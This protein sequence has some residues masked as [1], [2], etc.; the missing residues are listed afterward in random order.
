MLQVP[1]ARAPSAG[2][3]SSA[4]ALALASLAIGVARLADAQCLAGSARI[5]KAN[6][7]GQLNEVSV[8]DDTGANVLT[9]GNAAGVVSCATSVYNG[10]YCGGDTLGSSCC[11][12]EYNGVTNCGNWVRGWQN[13]CA[14]GDHE[15]NYQGNPG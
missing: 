11:A 15:G 10:D 12:A 13:S 4:A 8:F 14:F 7:G 1:R 3:R 6:G 2:A 5:F 9:T